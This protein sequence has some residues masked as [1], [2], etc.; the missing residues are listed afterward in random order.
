MTE[1]LT[2]FMSRISENFE[3]TRNNST[4]NA[5]TIGHIL[6]ISNIEIL[7]LSSCVVVVDGYIYVVK[8]FNFNVSCPFLIIMFFNFCYS[9]LNLKLIIK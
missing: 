3:I 4:N 6:L 9:Y 8:N 7:Y 1:S 5:N 2:L